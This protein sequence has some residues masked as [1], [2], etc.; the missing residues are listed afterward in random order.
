MAFTSWVFNGEQ[1]LNANFTAP[2]HLNFSK[3][4]SLVPFD[5]L[6]VEGPRHSKFGNDSDYAQ[7]WCRAHEA[8]ARIL[9]W[10]AEAWD[11]LSCPVTEFYSWLLGTATG[12]G[13]GSD[14]R[15]Y[16]ETAVLGWA[17]DVA[18][19]VPARGFD[20]VLLDIEGVT[21][22]TAKE[23]DAITFAV[24]ALKRAL[25]A[26]LPGNMVAWSSDTGP[27]FNYAALTSGGCVDLWLD[28]AYS[29]CVTAETHSAQRNRANAPLPFLTDPGGI[30]DTY[31]GLFG[32]P[33]ERL[34]ILLPWYGCA[35]ECAGAGG[36]YNGCPTTPAFAADSFRPTLGQIELHFLPNAT[37]PVYINASSI[38][39]VLNYR[40][41]TGAE[42]QLWYDDAET[43]RLK[44]AAIKAA[45]VNAVGMWTADSAG[46]NASIARALWDAMP[47]RV[48][49][50]PV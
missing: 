20:G 40:N 49:S 10:G 6:N 29:W 34:G 12:G 45:G 38:T 42:H 37:R 33:L 3:I 2:E 15:I 11:G 16:N 22:P 48:P 25:N 47:L 23:R 28:M 8:N 32:V 36:A 18:A 21:V 44:Y 7:L 1:A 50:Q 14:P 41:G 46:N 19:C 30:I 31:T 27:Y 9:T 35:F 26:T 17:A 5:D 43:L 13:E 4:S 39:K 24:C